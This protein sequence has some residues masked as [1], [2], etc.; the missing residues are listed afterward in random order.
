MVCMFHSLSHQAGSPSAGRAA[1]HARHAG[2]PTA[3]TTCSLGSMLPQAGEAAPN[4]QLMPHSMQFQCST[5]AA[6]GR[7][8]LGLAVGNL[9]PGLEDSRS[10]RGFVMSP[11]MGCAAAT[12]SHASASGDSLTWSEGIEPAF[13]SLVGQAGVP[14]AIGPC[15][16]G[17]SG[18]QQTLGTAGHVSL[19]PPQAAG[20]LP[21]RPEGGLKGA[22]YSIIYINLDLCDKGGW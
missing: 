19:C 18:S 22:C 16:N 2:S 10:R 3:C 6:I 5:Q 20:G 15:C 13:W 9:G 1:E 11:S 12:V 7:S 17:S 4:W 14:V 21:S 8:Y